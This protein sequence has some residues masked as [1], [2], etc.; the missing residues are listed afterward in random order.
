MPLNIF[1]LSAVNASYLGK[2]GAVTHLFK[3]LTVC[4]KRHLTVLKYALDTLSL[5]VKSSESAVVIRL[6][7]HIKGFIGVHGEE[8]QKYLKRTTFNEKLY[9]KYF[10]LPGR[11]QN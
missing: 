11:C 9:K 10:A 1:L 8:D 2:N 6:P 4:G 5:L 3:I 7:G